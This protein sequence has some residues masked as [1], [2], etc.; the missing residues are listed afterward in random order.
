MSKLKMTLIVSATGILL[1]VLGSLILVKSKLRPS[2]VR[3]LIVQSVQETLPGAE[4]SL[5]QIQ[6]DF[7]LNIYM[8][9]NDV[10]LTSKE[11]K[12]ELFEAT[13]CVLKLPLWTV[14]TGGGV[15]EILMEK[16]FVHY[17]NFG[18]TNNWKLA[19]QNQL[20]STLIE[21]KMEKTTTEV[22]Q[23]PGTGKKSKFLAKLLSRI[24]VNIK[25]GDL[26]IVYHLS[27]NQSGKVRIE[28][29]V[30]KGLNFESNTA[31]ELA[32]NVS[33]ALSEKQKAQF[34]LLAIGQFNLTEILQNSVLNTKAVAHI[35]NFVISK[36]DIQI[37]EIDAEIDLA[38]D[39]NNNVQAPLVINFGGNSISANVIGPI[40]EPAIESLKMDF[41][42]DESFNFLS[43]KHENLFFEKSRLHVDGKVVMHDKKLFPE[44]KF[45]LTT[46]LLYKDE[47]LTGNISLGGTFLNGEYEIT[48]IFEA[49]GG[50]VNSNLKGKLDINNFPIEIDK[51]SPFLLKISGNKMLLPKTIFRKLF[52]HDAEAVTSAPAESKL[53]PAPSDLKPIDV[54]KLP[55]GE[56]TCL[57]DNVTLDTLPMHAEATVT[58]KN[59]VIDIHHTFLKHADASGAKGLLMFNAEIRPKSKS[60]TSGKMRTQLEGF[61]VLGIS[62]LLPK[63][64]EG[65]TGIF[66]GTISGNFSYNKKKLAYNFA[67]NITGKNGEIKGINFREKVQSLVDKSSDTS[68]K[69]EDLDQHFDTLEFKGDLSE[70]QSKLKSFNFSG[71]QN[72]L[73]MKA[74]GVMFPAELKTQSEMFVT[75]S[76]NK[77]KKYFGTS[78]LPM[79]LRGPG[80]WPAVDDAYTLEK[81]QKKIPKKSE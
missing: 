7:G 21:P 30:I 32:S 46:P 4:V 63:I 57:F 71:G 78:V 10:K 16:P 81:L 2:S 28:K 70:V 62:P 17:L 79:R 1:L 40:G 74:N 26:N 56:I 3:N 11:K 72:K 18:A 51:Y 41:V 14:V 55:P 50:S 44:L 53:Q 36:T 35:K 52:V 8:R 43:I 12:S 60:E 73:S 19:L 59:G 22:F 23:T 48:S 65:I 25:M 47:F 31:F 20:L 38:I 13:S 42:L 75:L 54:I 27:D 33:V 69:L 66:T 64:F 5:G 9:I 34:E 49:Y 29:F 80:L 15:V 37:P 76:D 24:F 6:L 68:S 67:A 77:F 61:N 39:K 58:I 45:G